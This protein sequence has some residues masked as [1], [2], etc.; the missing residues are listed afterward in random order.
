MFIGF[1]CRQK[2]GGRKDGQT[3][4]NGLQFFKTQ[5]RCAPTFDHVGHQG[6]VKAAANLLHFCH[7]LGAFHKQ[8]VGPGLG[9]EL[10][11]AQRFVQTQGGTGIGA[12]DDEE[13]GVGASFH[14]H[15]DFVDH[16]L[17]GHDTAAQHMA[18][19]LGKFLVFQLNR[20]SACGFVATHRVHHI[21]QAAVAGVTI[22]NHRR[23][24]DAGELRHTVHHVCVGGQTRIRH[25]QI[26]RHGAVAG[27]VE[28][29]KAHLIGH[30]G[31][32]HFEHTRG[33]DQL[34][35]AQSLFQQGTALCVRKRGD[36]LFDHA[37]ALA[38]SRASIMDD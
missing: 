20:T 29:L 4:P 2:S 32:H 24:G 26:R 5:H 28:G 10:G 34:T 33:H 30:L 12:S 17:R 9:V 6:Q 37:M 38:R 11:T 36:T 19:F 22:T 35:L 3:I 1:G 14:R 13:V 27:H 25:A 16:V 31:R 7:R 18:T 8:N 15:A 21:Q 23:L